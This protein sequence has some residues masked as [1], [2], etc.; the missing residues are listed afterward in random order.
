M[1]GIL[2]SK[3][4][5]FIELLAVTVV[6]YFLADACYTL[7]FSE[8]TVVLKNASQVVHSKS[9]I[10]KQVN[11]SVFALI[12]KRN[13]LKVRNLPPKP[14]KRTPPKA[15]PVEALSISK[16]GFRL[17]G[18][19]LAEKPLRSCAIVLYKNRQ[20]LYR[21]NATIGGWKIVEVKRREIILQRGGVKERLL[22]DADNK[23]PVRKGG[24]QRVLKRSYVK[25]QL[26]N[27]S[28]LSQSVQLQPRTVGKTKGLIVSSLRSKSFFYDMGLR[29]G[30]LLVKANG[31]KLSSFSDAASLMAMLDS[32]SISLD[33]V[34][35][36]KRQ[37]LTYRLVN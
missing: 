30:D 18:T 9:A 34:R 33:I 10:E 25:K 24:K 4:K 37:T 19:V 23:R 3:V 11:R 22:I 28:A 32:N 36:K 8:Q 27:L 31:K 2:T 17:L 14:K 15:I 12:E 20:S 16:R 29:K 5:I 13:L 21:N 1:T 6:S 7:F 35:N 26:S